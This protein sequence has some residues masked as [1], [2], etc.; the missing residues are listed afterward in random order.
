MEG[1]GPRGGPATQ[2]RPGGALTLL[3]YA[4]RDLMVVTGTKVRLLKKIFVQL[5][6]ICLR[7]EVNI[8][9][10]LIMNKAFLH[11]KQQHQKNIL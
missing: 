4:R 9:S 3:Y 11:W 10:N 2:A 7:K 6:N 1:V 5:G 8:F